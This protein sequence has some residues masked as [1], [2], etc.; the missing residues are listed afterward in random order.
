MTEH[1]IE[2]VGRV[3][4][5]EDWARGL[6]PR[7]NDSFYKFLAKKREQIESDEIKGERELFNAFNLAEK[8]IAA[9]KEFLRFPLEIATHPAALL[10]TH[11]SFAVFLAEKI[12]G[13]AFVK[14]GEEASGR[15]SRKQFVATREVFERLIFL[16]MKAVYSPAE[17]I[18]RTAEADWMRGAEAGRAQAE[19]RRLAAI[20][21]ER[22]L[23]AQPLR[24]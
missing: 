11:N 6:M 20:C 1:L 19:K 2:D 5:V 10:F 14:K 9:V 24:E 21:E 18:A 3:A 23:S 8:D 16:R 12:L 7:Q 15:N 13:Y 17:I 4:R 22:K